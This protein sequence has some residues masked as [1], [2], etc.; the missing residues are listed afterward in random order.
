VHQHR[1][2]HNCMHKC[3]PCACPGR[4]RTVPHSSATSKHLEQP[5]ASGCQRWWVQEG[6]G[7]LSQGVALV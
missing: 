3:Y 7:R 2:Q 5:V 4:N 6:G 1:P